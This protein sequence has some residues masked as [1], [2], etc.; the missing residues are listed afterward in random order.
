MNL[1]DRLLT[2]CDQL[3]LSLTASQQNSMLSYLEQLAKWNRHF[4]LTAIRDPEDMLIKHILDSLAVAA[5]AQAD[6]ALDVGTGAGLPG[7]PLAILYPQQSWTLLDSNSKKTRFLVQVK[8][9]LKLDNV[10][11]QHTRIEALNN[12]SGYQV[13]TSRAFSSLLDFVSKCSQYVAPGGR[14]LA[15][16]GQRPDQ[17]IEAIAGEGLSCRLIPVNVPYL[18]EARHLVEL[19]RQP[20][21]S[22]DEETSIG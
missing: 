15:M 4:N 21:V 2:G 9:E 12:P 14:L 20:V 16:K 11:V 7:I 17:E 3:G 22:A 8:A 5:Y 10:E 1:S 6:N 18:A 19:Q 13:I